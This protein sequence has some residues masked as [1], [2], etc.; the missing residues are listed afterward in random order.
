[1]GRAFFFLDLKI[2]EQWLQNPL[3][4]PILPIRFLLSASAFRQPFLS[5]VQLSV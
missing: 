1:M 4:T 3:P 5:A 2:I